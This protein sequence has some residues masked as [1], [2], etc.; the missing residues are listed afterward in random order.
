PAAKRPLVGVLSP[1]LRPSP[2]QWARHPATQALA[3]LGWVEG[4]TVEFEFAFAEGSEDRLPELARALV[5]RGV[6][7][8]WARTSEAAVA[9]AR[10]TQTIPI[11][12]TNVSLPVE[13]GLVDSFSRPGRNA[14]GVAFLAGDTSQPVKAVELLRQLAP[15]ARRLGSIWS[16]HNFETV[17][18]GE[19]KGGYPLFE[20]SIRDLGFDY[21]SENVT[22]P[23]DYDAAFAKLLEWRTDTLLAVSTPINFRERHRIIA[24]AKR[25]RLPSAH[26]SRPFAEAGGLVAYGP[27]PVEIAAQS[28]RHVDRILRGARPAELAVELPHRFELTINLATAKELGLAVPQSLLLRAD[29]VIQ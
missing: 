16:E 8:I 21:R 10:A 2:E 23:A 28:A 14:T 12:F 7:L 5:R 15:Q 27:V 3:R 13:V 11:V 26:D 25:H 1:L 22:V 4:R 9:A 24:F 19:Y 17:S 20:K 18:G 29:R 6:D